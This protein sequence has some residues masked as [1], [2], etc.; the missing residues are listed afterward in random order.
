MTQTKT[1]KPFLSADVLQAL[2]D[3]QNRELERLGKMIP[4]NGK[5]MYVVHPAYNEEVDLYPLL[6]R[7]AEHPEYSPQTERELLVKRM[8][9]G[10]AFRESEIQTVAHAYA[11]RFVRAE[12]YKGKYPYNI[13]TD[14]KQTIAKYGLNNGKVQA[15]ILA[16]ASQLELRENPDPV[17]FLRQDNIYYVVRKW[18]HDFTV[19]RRLLSPD[20]FVLRNVLVMLAALAVAA[21][22]GILPFVSWPADF[23]WTIK[24]LFAL[25][26]VVS[27]LGFVAGMLFGIMELAK[28]TKWNN[29]FY[30]TGRWNTNIK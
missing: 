11:L 18:G 20:F 30:D 24:M 2:K 21:F 7:G 3:V 25:T 23:H 17:L 13:A 6:G 22:G 27:W 16:P 12:F 14:I 29:A 9:K 26:I 1:K 4:E 5:D 19:F 15:Y 8:E 28:S 10:D